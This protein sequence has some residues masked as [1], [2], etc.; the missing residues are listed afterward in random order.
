MS[1]SPPTVDKLVRAYRKMRDTIKEREEEHKAELAELREQM[2]EVSSALLD[3][4]NEN[5]LDNVKTPEGTVSRRV[6]TRYWTSDWEKMYDFIKEH[7]A[8]E[9][10]ER[11]IHNAN[12]RNFLDENPDLLPRGLQVDNRYIIQVRKPT[13]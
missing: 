12:M 1:D 10:L 4:L 6:N 11:R 13:S 5:N 7:E 3:F 9:L 8:F 2:E